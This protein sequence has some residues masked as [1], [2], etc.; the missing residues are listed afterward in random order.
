MLFIEIEKCDGE[1]QGAALILDFT[2]L[3]N[4]FLIYLIFFRSFCL[5]RL[6]QSRLR[7]DAH[8]TWCLI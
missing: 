4:L 2:L 7:S 3:L 1:I 6:V 8:S 5:S